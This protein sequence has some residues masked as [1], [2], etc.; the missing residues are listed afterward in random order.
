MVPGGGGSGW[1]R[2]WWFQEV[3]GVVGVG[4]GGSRRWWEWRV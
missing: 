2:G 4:D 3:V 1:C